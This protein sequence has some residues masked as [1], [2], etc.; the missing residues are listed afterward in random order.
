MDRNI[1]I[2]GGGTDIEAVILA[3]V[4]NINAEFVRVEDESTIDKAIQGTTMLISRLNIEPLPH[5]PKQTKAASQ[6]WKRRNKNT[7]K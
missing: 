4:N 2:I 6:A 7:K 5:I 1:A 3:S